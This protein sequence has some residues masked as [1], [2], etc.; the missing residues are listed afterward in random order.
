MENRGCSNLAEQKS[1]S[2][3]AHRAVILSFAPAFSHWIRRHGAFARCQNGDGQTHRG[4]PASHQRARAGAALRELPPGSQPGCLDLTSR[5]T[6]SARNLIEAFAPVGPV[7][8]GIDD[9]I[10]WRRD[11]RMLSEASTVTRCTPRTGISLRC[12][13]RVSA[14][15]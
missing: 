11:R 12:L 14:V 2:L 13:A 3:V 6:A 8:L 15:R 9:A 10:E 4:Q 5:V 7:V 1:L